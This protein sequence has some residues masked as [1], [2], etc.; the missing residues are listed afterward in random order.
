MTKD[1]KTKKE[2]PIKK[3]IKKGL[4]KKSI[5]SDTKKI[6]LELN[7]LKDKHLV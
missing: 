2:K 1:K 7:N 3:T 4:N 6:E 5:K